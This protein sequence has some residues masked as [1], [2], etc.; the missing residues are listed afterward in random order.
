MKSEVH[1]LLKGEIQ[2][3]IVKSELFGKLSCPDSFSE[4]LSLVT[5]NKKSSYWNVSYWRGQGNIDWPI[6]SAAIR[7]LR[8]EDNTY[9]NPKNIQERDVCFYE[10][11]LMDHARK[12]LFDYDEHNRQLSDFE[13]L[14]KMQHHG[15]ATRLVDFSKS[16]L[17]ALFFC[18]NE[19]Q[20]EDKYGLL[21]GVDTD[22][23]GGHEDHFDFNLTYSDFVKRNEQRE[24]LI[25]IS[26]PT[27]TNR[28]SAQHAVFLC[29]HCVKGK[30]GSLYLEDD[31][32]FYKFIGI[33]P[34]VKKECKEYLINYFDILHT[35]MFPDFSGYCGLNS[36][37]WAISAHTRW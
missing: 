20:N 28:I 6:D 37:A 9:P 5:Q 21:L 8:R 31:E 29:S 2:V 23:V 17:V 16:V 10:Q 27:V 3:H 32:M 19:T 12:N 24:A 14:A 36:T 25:C 7:R 15:A 30:Y 33:S 4:L 1:P 13:L 26:P 22:I 35:S 18:I 11:S 34:E